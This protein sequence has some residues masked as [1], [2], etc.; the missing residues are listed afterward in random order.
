MLLIMND[1]WQNQDSMIIANDSVC[2][3][4]LFGM[5]LYKEAGKQISP[6]MMCRNETK[7]NQETVPFYNMGL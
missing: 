1:T 2:Y 6:S 3:L 7:T 5:T 4:F